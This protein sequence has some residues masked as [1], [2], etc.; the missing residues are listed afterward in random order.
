MP[1]KVATQN[2]RLER[3][4]RLL[5]QRKTWVKISEASQTLGIPQ[6]TLRR[7][8]ESF[9]YREGVCWKWNAA[10]TVRLFNLEKWLEA[11]AGE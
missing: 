1:T 9:R 5:F 11:E 10:K 4:E 7:K 8:C 3:I 2:Q 6:S